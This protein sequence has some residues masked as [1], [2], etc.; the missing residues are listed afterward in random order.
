[1]AKHNVIINN[2]LPGMHHTA[3]TEKNFGEQARERHGWV[4]THEMPIRLAVRR[5]G[6]HDPVALGPLSPSAR[7]FANRDRARGAIGVK[8]DSGFTM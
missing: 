8:N 3:A 7:I 2:L 6:P 5:N 1:M 4:V